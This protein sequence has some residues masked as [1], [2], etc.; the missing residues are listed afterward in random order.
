MLVTLRGMAIYIP[1]LIL[2]IL[3]LMI[4]GYFL[5]PGTCATGQCK[6]YTC[7][8][9]IILPGTCA[10]Y[11]TF[12][13]EGTHYYQE[14]VLLNISR[15]TVYYQEPVLLN[16]SR[17]TVYYQE[18]VLLNI[19]RYTVYYQVPVLLNISRYKL[20]PGTCVTEHF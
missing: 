2:Y 4:T 20:L 14:P 18:P 17:Y 3:Q 15:Y 5:S 10:I 16:I 13:T 7:I 1:I 11:W 19:S 12:Q 6:V 8:I 9:I